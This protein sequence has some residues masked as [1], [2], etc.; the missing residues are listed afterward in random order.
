MSAEL[1]AFLTSWS[2][3]PQIVV[4]ILLAA[5]LYWV[6]WWRLRRRGRGRFRLQTWRA[7]SYAAGVTAIGLA[8]LSPLSTFDSLLLSIHMAQHLLLVIVAAPLIW[9]GAP[10]LP[11]L[12]ALPASWRKAV[13]RILVP[14]SPVHRLFHVLT[15]PFIA[16]AIYILVLAVWH[17]P[18]IYDLAQGEGVVHDVEH[19]MFLGSALI[20]WW[21]VIHPTGGRRRL[22]YGA[23]IFYLAPAVLEGNL[24]GALITFAGE[25]LYST[26][27][28]APRVFGLTALQDQEIGGLMMWVIGGLIL[29]IPIFV[30]VYLLVGGEDTE[31]PIRSDSAPVGSAR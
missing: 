16:A 21:P 29:V 11:I 9:L 27:R 12:W 15:T 25:P 19:L 3:D 1:A 20:Y 17:V 28:N 31:D 2:F 5:G 22:G 24:I 6:G 18:G 4:G 8:L 10:L 14:S 23:A 26:Y 7:V 13:G 30:L